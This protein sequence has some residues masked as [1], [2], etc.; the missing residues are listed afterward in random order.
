MPQSSARSSILIKPLT[1]AAAAQV[2]LTKFGFQQTRLTADFSSNTAVNFGVFCAV[3]GILLGPTVNLDATTVTL[4]IMQAFGA[5]AIGKFESLPR[6]YLGGLV[7]GVAAS[8]ATKYATGNSALI[9]GLPPSIPFIV[10][11]AVLLF[12]PRAWRTL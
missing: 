6:T 3:A 12:A 8:I 10:L 7:V 9:L 2:P 11:F 1:I 5:A 4:L